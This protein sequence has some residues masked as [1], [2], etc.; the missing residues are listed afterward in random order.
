MSDRS[1]I[2]FKS[3]VPQFTVPDIVR[4]AEYYRDI[5]GFEIAGYWNGQKAGFD[6]DPP[7][8]FGIVERDDVQLF[9]NRANQSDVRTGR[10]RGGYDAYF[11]VTGIDAFADEVRRR[12]AEIIDGPDDRVYGQREIVIRD[13]N[14]LILA[15]AQDLSPQPSR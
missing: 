6:T 11:H 10:A 13:C 15:F 14:G 9:F 2:R 1:H 8:V 4:T 12:G 3:A 5:L 7:P